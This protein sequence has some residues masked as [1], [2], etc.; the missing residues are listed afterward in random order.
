MQGDLQGGDGGTAVRH[1]RRRDVCGAAHGE[2]E[3]FRGD[4]DERRGG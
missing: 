2:D 3:R 1:G 4:L